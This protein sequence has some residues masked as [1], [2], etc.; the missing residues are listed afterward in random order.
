MNE[1]DSQRM[2]GVLEGMGYRLVAT[3]D[4]ASLVLMNTC[5][6]RHNPE[7]KVY[8][9]LGRFRRLKQRNPDLIIGVGGCVAQQ[10]GERILQ[11]EKI[12]DMVFGPDHF[13]ELPEMIARV[14]DGERVCMVKWQERTPGR[15]RNFIP[16]EWLETGHVD[17]CKA[18]VAITKGCDNFCTFCIVPYTRGREASREP[19]NVLREV[20]SLVERGA[21]EVWLLGQNVNSYQAGN[22]GFLELLDMVSRVDGLKRLR[23]TSPHPNDWNNALT[24]LM[25]ERPVIC[26]QLH[27]PFQAG[28]NRILDLMNRRHTIEEY[29]EKAR[30]LRARMPDIELSADLIV[31][32][33]TETEEDFQ[34][35]LRVMEE[36]RFG[37]LYSF[38]YSPRPGTRAVRLGDDVPQAVKD[39]RLQRVIAL[40]EIIHEER[41][42]RYH[43]AIEEILIDGAHPR[44]RHVMNGR[45][46][47]YRPVAVSGN[48]FE[49]G[50]L[51]Q[52]RITGH[53]NHWL[54]GEALGAAI[55]THSNESE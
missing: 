50:D 9:Q 1:H 10:E 45:T 30:Y 16:E 17:G 7:N 55:E 41:M 4:E 54:E 52:A 34:W 12:V 13:F 47:G 53:S 31:G 8:S 19:D 21:K 38:M 28:S 43:G 49:I 22:C 5:S 51:V 25:A 42:A 15:I 40:Q 26:R 27:L 24:D 35:T 32:F 14:R 33:P 44:R 48:G 18:Y 29:L 23:F 39:E 37:L 20:R 46:G 36:V 3:P 2:A 11:R 6:V